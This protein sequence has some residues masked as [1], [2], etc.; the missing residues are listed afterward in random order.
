LSGIWTYADEQLAILTPRGDP[1]SVGRGAVCNATGTLTFTSPDHG[2]AA[3]SGG[4]EGTLGIDMGLPAEAVI[5]VSST[6]VTFIIPPCLAVGTVVTRGRIDG[7][8]T[9]EFIID[10]EVVQIPDWPWQHNP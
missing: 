9:C 1:P 2:I 8:R 6:E 3:L 4:C 5:T 10:G 7:T